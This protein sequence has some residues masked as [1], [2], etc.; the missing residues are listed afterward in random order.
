MEEHE[1]KLLCLMQASDP[2][3][4]AENIT[5]HWLELG[6]MAPGHKGH[7]NKDKAGCPCARE[8]RRISDNQLSPLTPKMTS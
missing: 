4:P 1:R 7:E 5:F 6:H 8:T 3:M 2:V